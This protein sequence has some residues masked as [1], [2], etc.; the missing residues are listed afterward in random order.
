LQDQTWGT[1][2]SVELRCIE[3]LAG[4]GDA[5]NL[6]SITGA[7]ILVVRNADLV[8]NGSFHWEGLIIV[9]GNNVGFKTNGVD[10]KEI[11]G[12]LM[13]NETA[14]PGSET[15]IL[16][17]QGSVRVIFSRPALSQVVNLIPA[18]T[19]KSAYSSLPTT[20]S[21]DYWRTATPGP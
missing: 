13:I 4:P 15:A 14:S 1:Q 8:V 19:L 11:Y 10:S 3:G 6:G 20:I 18:S 7:G 12:S 5:V 21:Q 16:D 17:L 2:S 9:T